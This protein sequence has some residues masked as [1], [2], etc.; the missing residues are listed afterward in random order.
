MR[1]YALIVAIDCDWS[2]RRQHST[3]C[4]SKDQLDN[5]RTQDFA[6]IVAGVVGVFS[7]STFCHLMSVFTIDVNPYRGHM[8]RDVFLVRAIVD[9]DQ[10]AEN[11]PTANP[12]SIA[13]ADEMS[14][15]TLVWK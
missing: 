2:L 9:N 7:D 4:S 6:S 13:I 12:L 5:Y 15:E 10:S 1:E 8:C 3:R 11:H 14:P